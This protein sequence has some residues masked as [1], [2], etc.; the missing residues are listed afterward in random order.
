MKTY[1]TKIKGYGDKKAQFMGLGGMPVEPLLDGSF[2][3]ILLS[4]KV[5]GDRE[6]PGDAPCPFARWLCLHPLYQAPC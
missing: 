3:G 1:D 6:V 5:N 4:F 2:S